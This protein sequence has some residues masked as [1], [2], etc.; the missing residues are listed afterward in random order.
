MSACGEEQTLKLIRR[1]SAFHPL[2]TFHSEPALA[3]STLRAGGWNTLSLSA[4][5]P[6]LVFSLSKS[7]KWWGGWICLRLR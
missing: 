1:P 2:R 3:R 6:V 5:R 4:R 7:E